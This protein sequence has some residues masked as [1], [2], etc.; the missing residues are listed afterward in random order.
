MGS[1]DFPDGD[2]RML[3]GVTRFAAAFLGRVEDVKP[4]AVAQS[5]HAPSSRQGDSCAAEENDP[6]CD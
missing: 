5:R 3:F 1:E 2:A 6:P 4:R